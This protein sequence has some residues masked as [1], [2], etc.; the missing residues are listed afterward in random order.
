MDLSKLELLFLR[1]M[2][3]S[4]IDSLNRLSAK[5]HRLSEGNQADLYVEKGAIVDSELSSMHS[6]LSKV[7]DAIAI[8]NY[9]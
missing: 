8:F 9:T 6:L 7:N 5:Y 1:K 3:L 2:I 4:N